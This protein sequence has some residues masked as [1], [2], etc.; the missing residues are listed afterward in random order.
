MSDRCPHCGHK[1]SPR[2]FDTWAP[3]DPIRHISWPSDGMVT[4]IADGGVYVRLDADPGHERFY[5]ED[6]ARIVRQ[7]NG[8]QDLL[9]R[10]AA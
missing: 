1:I 6:W 9:V 7:K 8:G 5:D 10:R 3:G 4:K 2:F